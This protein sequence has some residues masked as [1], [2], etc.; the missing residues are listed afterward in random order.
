[1]QGPLLLTRQYP[2]V[3]CEGLELELLLV[4]M[5]PFVVV[6]KVILQNSLQALFPYTNIVPTN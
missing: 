4:A 5:C 1:M 3:E 6:S 2:S